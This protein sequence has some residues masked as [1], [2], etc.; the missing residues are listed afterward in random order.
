[1]EGSTDLGLDWTPV[2][3]TCCP[4]SSS[5][6]PGE[7]CVYVGGREGIP[8]WNMLRFGRDA[9]GGTAPK[10]GHRSLSLAWCAWSVAVR[11]GEFLEDTER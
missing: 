11:W 1:M 5:I 3:N 2:K 6:S 8:A 4:I 7:G 10:L 9:G